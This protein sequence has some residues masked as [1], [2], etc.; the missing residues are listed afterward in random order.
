MATNEKTLRVGDRVVVQRE[1][2]QQLLNVL[3]SEGYRTV[4]PTLRDHAVVYAE[5]S[6]VDELPI[7]W[8]EEQAGGAYRLKPR[9]DDAVFGYTVGPQSWK[10][11]LHPPVARLWR[12][13]RTDNGFEIV[14]E[15]DPDED[16]SPFAFFGVRPCELHAILIQDRVFLQNQF[17][18]P[19]YKSRRNKVF[20]VAVNCG[21]AAE[22]CFCSSLGTGPSVSDGYD[23]AM[24]EVLG[25]DR[26]WFLVEIG[27]EQG[28]HVVAQIPHGAASSE[29]VETAQAVVAAAAGQ[30]G[31]FLDTTDL[32][33]VL[34]RSYEH[35]RWEA[36]ASRCLSCANCTMVCPTCFCTTIEDVT[37]LSGNQAERIRRWDS[38]FSIEFSYMHGGS[39]RV[40][41]RSRYRQWMTHKLA[42]WVDQFGVLGCVGCGRCITW[43][44][45]GIDITEEARAIRKNIPSRAEASEEG[46]Y[47]NN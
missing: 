8:T 22:T 33:D 30:M 46:V 35:P 18:D 42:T 2:L 28:A 38:C 29:D 36:V 20:I 40:S 3:N 32:K 43:C 14:A 4:G 45:V 23:L 21:Q 44:P 37:D 11:F 26:H 16:D 10:R 15:S 34:Y 31:R 27:T 47:A 17:Q 5:V 6:T 41:G 19:I 7:G 24:T 1:D 12:S 13:R 25:T 9:D 39:I